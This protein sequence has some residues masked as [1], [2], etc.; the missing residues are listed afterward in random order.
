MVRPGS[1]I[2]FSHTHLAPALFLCLLSSFLSLL[3]PLAAA[4]A[5]RTTPHDALAMAVFGA[6]NLKMMGAQLGVDNA[7]VNGGFMK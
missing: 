5:F 4:A 7:D 2:F 6:A 3:G 1:H